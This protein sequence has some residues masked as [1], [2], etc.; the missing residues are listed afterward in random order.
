MFWQLNSEGFLFLISIQS[1]SQEFEVPR[2]YEFNKKEDYYTYEKD[3]I[4]GVNWLVN[5]PVNTNTAKRKEVNAFLMKWLTG[6]PSVTIELSQEIVTFMD[7]SD[8]LMVFLGG[9]ARYSLETNDKA[10]KL[11]G[12]LAGIES[13][14]EFYKKN[15]ES[16]GKNKAIQKYMKLQEKNKLEKYVEARV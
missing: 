4:D 10:N 7:C 14:I 13:V 11:K 5:T 6:S 3:V 8:C 16:L 2:G 15:Q 12:N 1:F 9:W